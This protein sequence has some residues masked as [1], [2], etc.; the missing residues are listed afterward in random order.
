MCTVAV[1]DR[2]SNQFH[3]F[4][5]QDNALPQNPSCW[6]SMSHYDEI[7]SINYSLKQLKQLKIFILAQPA[8]HSPTQVKCYLPVRP[9]ISAIRCHPPTQNRMSTS[10][11]SIPPNPPPLGLRTRGGH[12]LCLANHLAR[13]PIPIC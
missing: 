9:L 13:N 8:S 3:S 10:L 12:C 1:T 4:I 6:K 2:T 11:N 5:S 7:K